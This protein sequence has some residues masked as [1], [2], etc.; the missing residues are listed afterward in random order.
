MRY[1]CKI[2]ILLL[3]VYSFVAVQ[4]I[5][6]LDSLVLWKRDGKWFGGQSFQL[7]QKVLFDATLTTVLNEPC[8]R[9]TINL[10]VTRIERDN[11]DKF[12]IKHWPGPSADPIYIFYRIENTDTVYIGRFGADKVVVPGNGYV[13]TEQRSNEMFSRR[14]KFR[15]A[16]N[17]FIE[18]KQPFFWVGIQSKLAQDVTLYSDTC[19]T[20][21]VANLVK[22]QDIFVL[23]NSGDYYL[24]RTPLGITGWVYIEHND[25]SGIIFDIFPLGD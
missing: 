4:S 12:L 11:S 8:S 18:V 20:N 2:L 5:E 1:W 3:I 21:P 13:Y 10:I 25:Y 19:R 14:R 17:E 24:V 6:G 7:E 23:V 9:D 16:D 15:I 22:G